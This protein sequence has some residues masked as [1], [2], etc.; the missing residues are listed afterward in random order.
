VKQPPRI[1]YCHCAHAP[2]ALVADDARRQ[3]LEALA[4][5]GA[6]FEAVADLCGLAARR[7]PLLKQIA[8]GGPLQIVACYP[9]AVRWLFAYAGAPLPKEAVIHNLRTE[10]AAQVVAHL[11]PRE[12]TARRKAKKEAAPSFPAKGP[13]EWIPWFP[14]IDRDRCQECRQCLQ[15]CLFGVY[16]ADEGGHIRVA[17]PEKCKTGCPACARICP[18]MAII[19]PK[20]PERPINGDE[21]RPEEATGKSPLDF[22]SLAGL[23]LHEAVRRRSELLRKGPKGGHA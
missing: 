23:D 22:S 8:G 14:V 7:D 2:T 4:A 20:C 19:F 21:V 3:V 1:L 16:A 12:P 13:A 9:R 10:G 5:S 18:Q 11:A 15:F 17:E 6:A